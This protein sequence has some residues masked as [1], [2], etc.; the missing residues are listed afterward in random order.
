MTLNQIKFFHCKGTPLRP[1]KVRV[2][3]CVIHSFLAAY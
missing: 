2:F 3:S 1:A